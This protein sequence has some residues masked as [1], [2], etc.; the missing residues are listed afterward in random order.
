MESLVVQ[1]RGGLLGAVLGIGLSRRWAQARL[2]DLGR[3]FAVDVDGS[4]NHVVPALRLT[5]L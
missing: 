3:H 2:G 5:M 4:E 1:C